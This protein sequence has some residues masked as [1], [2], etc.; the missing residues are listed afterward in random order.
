[1]FKKTHLILGKDLEEQLTRTLKI[2]G[3]Y[4]LLKFVQKEQFKT[5]PKIQLHLNQHKQSEFQW[6]ALVDPTN[7]RT[8]SQ[9]GLDLMRKMLHVHPEERISIKD[10]LEH[11]F[12]C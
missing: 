10:A 11:P 5:T 7:T 9:D 2:C 12:L 1:M 4:P 3:S 6:E 8:V